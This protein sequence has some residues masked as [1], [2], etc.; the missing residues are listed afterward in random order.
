L[1]PLLRRIKLC[2]LWYS[3]FLS[4]TWSVNCILGVLN[5]WANIHLSVK[6]YHVCSFVIGLPHSGWYFLVPSIC[7]R[8]LWIHCFNSWVVN[9]VI[10]C[11][12]VPH[13]LYPSLCWGTSGFFPDCG[14]YK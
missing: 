5:L 11:V 9:C 10:Y 4:F 13:F 1:I 14:Y 12:N 2:S 3:F 8:I 7:L 6:A